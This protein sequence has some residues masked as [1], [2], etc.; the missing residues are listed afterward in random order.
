MRVRKRQTLRLRLRLESA[1]L[2]N[3]GCKFSTKGSHP[4]IGQEAP[5]R[6]APRPCPRCLCS[7]AALRCAG[8]L[9]LVWL[10]SAL[11][12]FLFASLC[13]DGPERSSLPGP[14]LHLSRYFY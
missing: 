2:P 13:V 3:L 5:G 12:L 11:L 10:C 6:W 8:C 1:N 14:R 9:Q 7:C 4:A